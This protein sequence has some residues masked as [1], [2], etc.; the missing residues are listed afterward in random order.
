MVERQLQQQA[1]IYNLYLYSKLGIIKIVQQDLG[2]MTF[3]L[4]PL[5]VKQVG[6]RQLQQ[7]AFIYNLYF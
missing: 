1:L 7:Q 4:Q 6:E 3:Q 2:I 5:L